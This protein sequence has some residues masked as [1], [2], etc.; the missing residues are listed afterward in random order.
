M[1]HLKDE[2]S[3]DYL[4]NFLKSLLHNPYNDIVAIPLQLFHFSCNLLNH[5]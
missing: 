1:C 5:T 4:H 3:E 2:C